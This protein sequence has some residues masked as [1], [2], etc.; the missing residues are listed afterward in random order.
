MAGSRIKGITIEI[1][2]DSTKLQQALRGIDKSLNETQ[3]KLR[4]VDKLLKLDPKNTELLTQ[5]QKALEDAIGLT[6]VRLDALKE[7]QEGIKEG[8][9]EWEALQREIIATEQN[10]KDLESAQRSFGSVAAQQI[11]QVGKD[12]QDLGGKISAVGQKLAPLSTAAAG[13]G[14]GL[15]GLGYNAV[16]MADNLN[17]MSKQTGISTDSLQKMKYASDLIDVSIDDLTGAMSK[18]KKNMGGN[19]D[20]FKDLGVE[21]T[22]TDGSM[23][24]VEEVFN[25][26]IAALSN[27]ENE[28][29]R[30]QAAMSIFGKSAD[31]L[32]GVID[33]GGEALKSYGAEAESLGLIMSG[34][35]LNSLNDINDAI[36]QNKAKVGAATAELG[37]TV[38]ESLIPLIDPLTAGIQKV[39]EFLQG[40]SPAQTQVI[41]GVVGAVAALAPLIMVIGG[42]VSAIGTVLAAAPAVMAV[43]GAVLSPIGLVVIACVALAVA[44]VKNWDKIKTETS[45]MVEAV[46]QKWEEFKKK[47]SDTWNAVKST[48]LSA[49]TNVK[50]RLTQ[51]KNDLI[52]TASGILSTAKTKFTEV[53]EAIVSPITKA[54]ETIKT[55]IDTIKGYFS[56]AKFEFPKIKLPHFSWDWQDIGGIVKIPRI[57]V[58]W[59][60]KAYENPFLFT[61]PTVM[62]TSAGLKGFGDKSGGEIVYGH[63]SLMH[64]IASA[65]ASGNTL[66]YSVMYSAMS[67]ALN[68]ADLQVVIGQR[69]FG[70]I[71]REAGAL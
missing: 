45:K 67:A 32:A 15:V 39:T 46:K 13:V 35:T 58:D 33:D 5:K 25:D 16:T 4:D 22:N 47:I 12:M 6:K 51:M 50:T 63:E 3:A 10:L 9:P 59:Y 7:A 36:D 41:L 52:S 19:A 55:A 68:N 49:V 56:G 17:S 53:K 37:A 64:D 28:V 42:V 20:A 57:S 11:S 54:K 71:L 31:S 65:V 27:I 48:V 23:R 21:V 2:G 60:R 62:Q 70:R 14:A 34:D 44:V 61:S 40:L 43:L 69:E 30:D 38:A 8:T 24:S 29:E 66:L 26:T 1:N 18:M